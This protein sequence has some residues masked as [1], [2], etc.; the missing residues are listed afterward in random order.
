MRPA[1]ARWRGIIV[2]IH[3]STAALALATAGYGIY[4]LSPPDW[5]QRYLDR[6]EAGIGWHKAAGLSVLALALAWIAL[7]CRIARPPLAARGAMRR[8]V[9]GVHGLLLALLILLPASGYAMSALGGEGVALPGGLTIPPLLQRDDGASISFSYLHK[10]AGYT[11]LG[12]I[13]I[14]VAGALRHAVRP[15]DST[16]RAMLPRLSF[17]K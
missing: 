5:G 15:G 1:C 8:W 10:W 13:G 12:L 4:L 6:Y 3:W 2:L 14:H 17:K 16:L 11:L 9:L 7:R